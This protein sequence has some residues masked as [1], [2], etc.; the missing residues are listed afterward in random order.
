MAGESDACSL[1]LASGDP[2]PLQRFESIIPKGQSDATLRVAAYPASLL[3]AIFHFFGGKHLSSPYA[4]SEVL[5]CS[6]SRV[7][8]SP[9]KIHTLTPITP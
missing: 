2:G 7:K 5:C 4:F 1:N 9:R 8:T 6:S 3:L